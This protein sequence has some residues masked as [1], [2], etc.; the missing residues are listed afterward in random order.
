[1]EAEDAKRLKAL[2]SE[3]SRLKR[4]LAEAHLDIK[5]LKLREVQHHARGRHP[6]TSTQC[7][8]SCQSAF[9]EAAAVVN[10]PDF[11]VT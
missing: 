3:N 1:M 8:C 6:R 5:S 4:L 9:T 2:E 10:D 11:D 7:Q